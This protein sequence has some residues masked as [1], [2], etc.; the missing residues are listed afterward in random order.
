MSWQQTG[1]T[2]F[3]LLLL[4]I[5]WAITIRNI[6]LYSV[7]LLELSIFDLIFYHDRLNRPLKSKETGEERTYVSFEGRPEHGNGF[8]TSVCSLIDHLQDPVTWYGINYTGTQMT[9]WDFQNK[10]KSGWTGK[11][12]FVLKVPLRHLRPSVIYSVPC[13]WILQMA[14]SSRMKNPLRWEARYL[15]VSA[16]DPGS[17]SLGS[18]PDRSHC[19]YSWALCSHSASLHPCVNKGIV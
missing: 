5:D 19:V 9:Q 1:G 16:L 15:I 3:K 10:G 6:F 2:F 14:Y 12:S 13:D 4:Y 11:S 7:S 8:L 18:S 17:R